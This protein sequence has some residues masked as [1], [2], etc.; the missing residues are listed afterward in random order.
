[1][2]GWPG[3]RKIIR[4]MVFSTQYHLYQTG[5]S[6]GSG[7]LFRAGELVFFR[8]DKSTQKNWTRQ[9]ASRLRSGTSPQVALP[10]VE[11]LT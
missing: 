3:L 9:N 2:Q 1:M 6:K 8:S 7:S 10:I 4:S 11:G 5:I